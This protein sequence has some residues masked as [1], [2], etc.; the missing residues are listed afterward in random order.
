MI[1]TQYFCLFMFFFQLTVEFSQR[2]DDTH[3]FQHRMLR[4]YN[5]DDNM[6][7]SYTMNLSLNN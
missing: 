5:S 3:P 7:G 2:G 4:V 6:Y 1:T